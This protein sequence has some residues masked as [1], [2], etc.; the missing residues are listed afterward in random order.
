MTLL[1]LLLNKKFE[2]EP[3]LL[4]F[5]LA[6]QSF[7]EVL[8]DEHLAQQISDVRALRQN[9]TSPSSGFQ[10]NNRARGNFAL[11]HVV[12]HEHESNE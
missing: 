1:Y 4:G 9:P 8:T 2:R 6:V 11:K 10:V 12:T 3:L 5:L 7:G